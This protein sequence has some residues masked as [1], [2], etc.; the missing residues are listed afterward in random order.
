MR[1]GFNV[2]S[3]ASYMSISITELQLDEVNKISIPTDAILMVSLLIVFALLGYFLNNILDNQRNKLVQKT[4]DDSNLELVK[5]KLEG[6][7]TLESST[8]DHK[9]LEKPNIKK[10]NFLPPSKLLGLGSLA[11]VAIGGASLLGLQT[12]Q[13]SYKGVNTNQVSIKP[14]N[15]STKSL[16]SM[17]EMQASNKTQTKIQKNNYINPFL[18]TRSSSKYNNYNQV[19]EGGIEMPFYF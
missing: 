4:D 1:R 3:Y 12:L 14:K 17:V 15:Q 7:L 11:V 10:L 13:K 9:N 8:R 16:S 18:S 5:E 2:L 19:K 6:Q